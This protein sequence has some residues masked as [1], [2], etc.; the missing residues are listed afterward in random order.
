MPH[1]HVVDWI[2]RGFEPKEPPNPDY[3]N[4]MDVDLTAGIMRPNCTVKLPYP[5]KRIGY[6][7]ITC[8]KCRSKT[9]VTTAG[10]RDDPRSVRLA[11]K[12]RTDA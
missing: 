9:I 4:G 2:D 1:H 12:R 7:L 3:P 8:T 5:A 10:R 11:C 6:Y